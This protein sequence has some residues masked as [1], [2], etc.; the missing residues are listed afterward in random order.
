MIN[1]ALEHHAGCSTKDHNPNPNFSLLAATSLKTDRRPDAVRC[2]EFAAL[3]TVSS[4][5][6]S[7]NT[8]VGRLICYTTMDIHE[9]A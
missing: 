2:L 3:A 7:F 5:S 8:I 9:K 4:Q 6:R 1:V